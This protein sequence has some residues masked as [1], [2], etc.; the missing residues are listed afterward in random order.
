[1]VIII[2]YI[3]IDAYG[4]G[5]NSGVSGNGIVEKD[6]SLLISNYIYNRLNEKGIKAYLTRTGDYNLSD[7]ERIKLI[8]DEFGTSSDVIVISNRLKNDRTNGVDV[9]Y[10]LRDEDY[11]AENIV[12]FLSD[13]GFNIN[14][15]YQLRDDD[16]PSLDYYPIIRDSEDNETIIIR[17]GNVNDIND[18]NDIKNRWQEM[19][20]AVVKAI[21]IYTGG[22]YVDSGYYTVVSGDTLYSIARKFNT[23]V[24]ILKQINNLTSN[25]L[26]IGQ[27]LKIPSSSESEEGSSSGSGDNYFLYTVRSGDSLYA[28][29]RKY[30][31]TVDEIKKI[32]NLINNTL[33][34]GQVLKISGITN[35]EN[36]NTNINYVVVSGDSLYSIARKYNT[37]V[38]EIKRL[39]NLINNNLSIGQVLKIPSTTNN[40]NYINYIVVSGDSLYA[41]ARKYNTTVDEIK[42]LNNLTSN[43]LSIGQNL[44]IPR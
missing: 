34:I 11:L 10:A 25:N 22:E 39:N 17:Y 33:S 8:Q 16:D 1:M 5:N 27:L 14:D 12:N 3:V 32:N 28:I 40:N 44:K 38:D 23:S 29:A 20:E 31:T 13:D 36:I 6:Y 43:N 9:I 35:N 7:E 30:N 19:A 42:R 18:S 24:D 21:I 26:T 2:K 4:G 15:F 37:T 41:I